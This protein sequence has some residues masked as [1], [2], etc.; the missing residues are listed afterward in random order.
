M[1]TDEKCH[2]CGQLLLADETDLCGLCFRV[3][4]MEQWCHG[5]ETP[6]TDPEAVTA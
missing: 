4:P 1:R 6:A 5:W 2:N 3:M